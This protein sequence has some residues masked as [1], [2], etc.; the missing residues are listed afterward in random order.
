MLN[1]TELIAF[2]EEKLKQENMSDS[3]DKNNEIGKFQ[4]FMQLKKLKSTDGC[5]ISRNYT[6]NRINFLLTSIRE[7]VNPSSIDNLIKEY[8]IDYYSNLFADGNNGCIVKDVD[9]EIEKYFSKFSISIEDEFEIKFLKL[10][11]II[12]QELYGFGILDELVF[13]SDFNEVACNRFDYIWIQYKGIK[14]RIPNNKFRFLSEEI[15][16]KTIENRITSNA[17]EE[18]NAG[19]PVIYAT[20]LNGF[21]ITAARPPISKNYVVNIRMFRSKV[22]EN[23]SNYQ[24]LEGKMAILIEILASK[25]RRNIAIIGEQGAGKTTAANELIISKLDNDLSIG[26][27]EN[28]HELNLSENY[29]QKNVVELQYVKNFTPSDITEI[30][31]RFNRDIIIYGEVRNH[32]EA[33]EMIKAMLRQARGSLFTFHSSGINRMIH[34][35]RQLL[36]QTGFYTNFSE[37][38]F[39]VA[40]AV[41]IVIQIKLDRNTGKRY[42]FKISEITAEDS[43]MSYKIRDLF[44]FNKENQVYKVN[45]CG[46]SKKMIDSCLEFEMTKEDVDYV[47]RIFNIQDDDEFEYMVNES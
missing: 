10:V 4:K 16:S 5:S 21:R 22:R 39:D 25:G 46:L 44:I 32:L 28:I 6:K 43:V 18:M 42:V 7:C 37:A 41:D 26:L 36:M 33:F 35:L 8:H 19:E 12:Y 30:F 11:Q 20:L 9:E 45:S 2:I 17:I 1:L 23:I 31:F 14:R 34:D 29:P 15:Y 38:Q 13:E 3:N 40:D 24:L 27:A 47:Q